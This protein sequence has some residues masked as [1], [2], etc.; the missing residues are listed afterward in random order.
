MVFNG[1]ML[2]GYDFTAPGYEYLVV[3]Y[4]VIGTGTT[5]PAITFDVITDVNN[6]SYTSDDGTLSNGA[7]IWAVYS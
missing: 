5:E 6:A 1:S 7:K 4:E 3:E 2:T